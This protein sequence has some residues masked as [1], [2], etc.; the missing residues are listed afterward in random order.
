M[1]VHFLDLNKTAV[2]FFD[3][4]NGYYHLADPAAGNASSV[5][6]RR[7]RR[8]RCIPTLLF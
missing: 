6:S 4:L 3:I 1:N 5:W 2:L 8:R 7:Q